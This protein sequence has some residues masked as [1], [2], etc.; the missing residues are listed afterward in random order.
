[1]KS[2]TDIT[3]R[4]RFDAACGWAL[5]L[6]SL[7]VK[8]PYLGTFLTID[9]PRWIKGAGQL[10][11]ALNSGDWAQTYW[12]FFP[13]V[14]NSWVEGAILWLLSGFQ[15]GSTLTDFVTRQVEN[16]QISGLAMRLA[17]VLITSAVMPWLYGWA[18]NLVGRWPALLGIALLAVDPFV[19]AHARLVNGDAIV[20]LLM[21][22]AFLALTQ[23]LHAPSLTI[24]PAIIAG[25]LVGIGLLTK[26]Q[27]LIA[28]PV[29]LMVLL[30]GYALRRDFGFWLK[31]TLVLGATVAVVFVLLWP[32][33][34][35]APVETLTKM[36]TETFVVGDI[37]STEKVTFFMGQVFEAQSPLFYPL[38]L[39]FRLTPVNLIG[40]L[41]A[42]GWFWLE[43]NPARRRMM[44]LLAAY[45]ALVVLFAGIS[46]KKADRYALAVFPAIDL[47]AGIGL[48]GAL[49]YLV[50]ITNWRAIALAGGAALVL[51]QFAFIGLNYPYVL[52]Y[53][54]PLLGGY[55][56]AAERVPVGR[57][58]GLE[59]AA[60]WINRQPD[61][62]TATVSP[63]YRNVTNAYLDGKSLGFSDDGEAQVLADY[64]VFYITQ[65]QR[66][67]PFPGLVD[68]FDAQTPVH[69]EYFNGTP[70]V[71]VYRQPTPIIKLDG[72]PKIVGRG[73][74]MGYNVDPSDLAAGSVTDFNLYL[75]TSDP[76]L[77]ANEDF[78]VSLLDGGGQLYGTWQSDP[79]NTWVADGVVV[80]RGQLALPPDMPPGEYRLKVALMDANID[81]EVAPFA[82][83]DE[84]ITVE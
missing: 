45:V 44:M 14:A 47:L 25:V 23:T 59:R 32:A 73:R 8:L 82:F 27:M 53:Y 67:M 16:P 39:A 52:T 12:H 61:A 72:R 33:M 5:A 63:Y 74:L 78:A 65:T 6:I 13:G 19:V 70:Y 30:T 41:A 46:P 81:S 50:R 10:L 15:T 48:A 57:G 68:Y 26:T 3:R 1:M 20:A 66:R 29:L 62:A 54:N 38:A 34:W 76:M 56:A 2:F 83:D 55:A 51:A 60:A 79:D 31:S 18:K 64:V 36:I 69:V 40:L 7:L 28:G 4:P 37:D 11:L 21:L 49:G 84:F 75:L 77:P 42:I 58:E 71:W 35:V 17:G 22:G 24:R 43:K 80:W 9:E